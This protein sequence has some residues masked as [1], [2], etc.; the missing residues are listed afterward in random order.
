MFLLPLWSISN[1]FTQT[2]G[3]ELRAHLVQLPHFIDE[4][5]DAQLLQSD[6]PK[7]KN[8]VLAEQGLE[9]WAPGF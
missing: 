8:Q 4:E 6:F 3:R 2:A 7:P 5:I 9:H 1:A